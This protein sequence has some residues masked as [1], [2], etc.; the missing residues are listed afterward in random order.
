MS[1]P[2]REAN[3]EINDKI[4]RIKMRG[5]VMRLRVEQRELE[6]RE[7]R[8]WLMLER[9]MM[10]VRL[11]EL[12]A[13]READHPRHKDGTFSPKGL[14]NGSASDTIPVRDCAKIKQL[15]DIDD[16]APH[17]LVTGYVDPSLTEHWVGSERANSH[18]KDYEKE[19]M[20]KE[21]YAQRA[22]DLAEMPVSKNVRGFACINQNIIVR[23][24]VKTKDFVK[25]HIHYGVITMFKA[26]A[27]YYEGQR[28]V[29]MNCRK[30]KGK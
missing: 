16:K 12:R 7:F 21:Q 11:A 24:D 8:S 2:W 27:S 14:T 20:T 25:A 15:T 6:E 17:K 19:G 3:R 10:D 30:K 5:L 22:L 13:F 26:E 9:Y 4:Y 18:R 23:Y 28:K 1:A 29:E